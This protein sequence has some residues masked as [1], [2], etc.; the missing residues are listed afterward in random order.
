MRLFL[1]LELPD[2]ERQRLAQYPRNQ[3][4]FGF[5]EGVKPVRPENLHVTLKFLGEVPDPRLEEVR[6]ALEPVRL[7]GPIELH[8]EGV[9]FFP[10]RGLI[11]VFVALLAGDVD[12]LATLYA[13]AEAA[14]EPLGFAREQ[15]PFKP[16]V[17][18]ARADHR[19][20][21]PGVCRQLVVK[22]PP[23]RGDPFTV[24]SFVL[25]QSRLKPGGSEYVPLAR[26]GGA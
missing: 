4:W 24:D 16:H 17:T 23:P 19:R 2:E 3:E 6:E 13:E 20:K 26:F 9:T 18:L 5:A 7:P 10:P 21:I 1:A 14:L 8:A 15:R 22:T 25:F 11:R 12:R